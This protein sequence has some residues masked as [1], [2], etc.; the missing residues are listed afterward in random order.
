MSERIERIGDSVIVYDDALLDQAD[1][2]TFE[3]PVTAADAPSP[4]ALAGRGSTH[5]VSLQGRACVLRHYYRGGMIRR[6]ADDRFVWAGQARTRSFRE[7]RLLAALWDRELPVPRPVAARYVR[8]GPFYTADLIT[9]RLPGVRS[10]AAAL[11]DAAQPEDAWIGIGAMLARFHGQ[12]VF[13][14]DLNAHNIQIGDSGETYLLDFDRGRIMD[15]TG[16]WSASNLQ[17]L[18]RSLDKITRLDGAH[19]TES[20]WETLMRGYR[21]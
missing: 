11:G 16:P 1:E 15:G 5:F 9:E 8:G 21:A 2:R 4:Q 20:D 7:W 6:L 12:L 19:F 17:R 18:R 3:A 13:H 10:L 14:A